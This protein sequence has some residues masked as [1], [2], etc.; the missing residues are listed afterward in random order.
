M[1][2]LDCN[3]DG[4]AITQYN[5]EYGDI[6]NR[7]KFKMCNGCY[8][9][10]IAAYPKNDSNSWGYM[11]NYIE[12]QLF[13]D[14]DEDDYYNVDYTTPYGLIESYNE[15]LDENKYFW[16]RKEY[17][18]DLKLNPTLN[19]PIGILKHI[20]DIN[21]CSLHFD[22]IYDILL[23][24]NIDNAYQIANNITNYHKFGINMSATIETICHH[25]NPF[26][27]WLTTM[28]QYLEKD[29]QLSTSVIVQ[30]L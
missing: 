4:Y 7:H 3:S 25:I 23:R 27:Q 2:V 13:D 30:L 20:S 18:N 5:Q 1:K 16:D 26:K 10:N 12:D 8:H 6:L 14:I 22:N 21:Y 24:N 29:C 19:T 9:Y 11:M 17:Y 28:Y 15:Y